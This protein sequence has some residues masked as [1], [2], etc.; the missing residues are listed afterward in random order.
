VVETEGVLWVDP[1]FHLEQP[2]ILLYAKGSAN[3][4][5]R[6]IGR[7]VVQVTPTLGVAGGDPRGTGPHPRNFG[8]VANW[9]TPVTQNAD[10]EPGC[11]ASKCRGIQGDAGG[12]AVDRFNE[13]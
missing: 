5:L 4:L 12:L 8:I 9:I 1:P 7:G 11:S 13:D 2:R 10:I 3:S 6:L